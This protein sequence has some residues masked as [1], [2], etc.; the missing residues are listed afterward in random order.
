MNETEYAP[1]AFEKKIEEALKGLGLRVRDV[2]TFKYKSRNYTH[3]YRISAYKPN[4]LNAC[5]LAGEPQ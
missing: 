3:E 4:P 2:H 1:N 5:H